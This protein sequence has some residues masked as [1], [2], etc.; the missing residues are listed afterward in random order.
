MFPLCSLRSSVVLDINVSVLA[1]SSAGVRRGGVDARDRVGTVHA[2]TGTADGVLAGLHGWRRGLAL[3]KANTIGRIGSVAVGRVGVA[4]RVR[5]LS[6]VSVNVGG[7]GSR[8][9]WE[10]W[11]LGEITLAGD[12]SR[13]FEWWGSDARS[14]SGWRLWG[15]LAGGGVRV[16]A[17]VDVRGAVDVGI[18]VREVGAAWGAASGHLTALRFTDS[19]LAEIDHEVRTR[20]LTLA[21]GVEG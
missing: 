3:G 18:A 1:V 21:T 16:L 10:G 17:G 13:A 15:S 4:A 5:V 12:R 19:V 2:Y 14:W 8:L 7:S 11:W 9:V 6:D 20:E